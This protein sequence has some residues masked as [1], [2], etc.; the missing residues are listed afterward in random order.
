MFEFRAP[1]VVRF[2]AGVFADVGL[3][4]RT[5]A[6]RHV[7]LTC[8]PGMR[9]MGLI[10]RALDYLRDAGVSAT[11]FD[12]VHPEPLDSDVVAGLE[13]YREAQC[14]GLIAVGGGSS[15]DAAK[16]IGAMATNEGIIADYAMGGKPLERPKVPLLAIPTTAGTGSEVTRVTIITDTRYDVKLLV[17]HPFLIPE[18]ALVDPALTLT[19]PPRLT[20]AT[21]IDA[22]THALE[23]YISVRATPISDMYALEAIQLIAGNLRQAWASGSNARAREHMMLGSLLAGLAFGNSSVGLVHGM[24]RPIGAHFHIPHGISNAVLLTECMEFSMIGAPDRFAAIA[25]AMGENVEALSMMQAA[26]IAVEA[27][28]GLCND[29]GVPRLLDLGVDRDQFCQLMSKMAADGIA[30][31]SPGNNPRRASA[32]DIVDIYLRCYE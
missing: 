19:M 26:R 17:S 8:D 14:D 24:A 4:A 3:Q 23:A 28:R 13:A 20:M 29:V 30:S 6:C 18:V 12:G 15:I 32:E 5:L 16:A 1:A 2:G 9:A 11:V 22:L 27:I 7:L 21:G 25:S 31:G 10:D